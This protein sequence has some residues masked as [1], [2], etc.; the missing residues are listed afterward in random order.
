MTSRL[1]TSKRQWQLPQGGAEEYRFCAL[2]RAPQSASGSLDAESEMLSLLLLSLVC[3]LSSFSLLLLLDV[4]VVVVAVV[5]V[6]VVAVQLVGTSGVSCPWCASNFAT[7]S[8]ESSRARVQ[9]VLLQ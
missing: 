5:S 4:L 2:G 3:V 7:S 1:A 6:G 9:A 8:S